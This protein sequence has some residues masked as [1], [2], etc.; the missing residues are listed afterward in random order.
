MQPCN[1]T[2]HAQISLACLPSLYLVSVEIV[3]IDFIALC[4]CHQYLKLKILLPTL[5][6]VVILFSL[7]QIREPENFRLWHETMVTETLNECRGC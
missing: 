2:S 1:D 7:L 4:T 6:K 5:N 3:S